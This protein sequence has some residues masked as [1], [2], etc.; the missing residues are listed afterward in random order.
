[1]KR[2]LLFIIF[3]LLTFFSFGIKIKAISNIS[4]SVGS[5]NPYF[6]KGIYKYNVYLNENISEIHINATLE[7]DDDYVEGIGNIILDKG[8]NKVEIKVHKKNESV[9]YYIFKIFVGEIKEENNSLLKS[10]KVKGYDI[11]F[12]SNVFN[13]SLNILDEKELDITYETFNS[14]VNVKLEGNS[15]L[16]EG[17]NIILITVL[18][19]ESN[20]KSIYKINVNKTKEVYKEVFD[21]VLDSNV[22]SKIIL[23]DSD[24]ILLGAAIFIVIFFIILFI[25]KLIFI[26]KKKNYNRK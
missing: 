14:N 8:E 10:L 3:Y 21:N 26:K 25:Y 9:I 18:S 7:E 12:S 20:E 11:N 4:L 2:K 23:N 13:Y 19:K 5:L 22:S 1:M 16:K 24:K 6:N 15:N 17:N